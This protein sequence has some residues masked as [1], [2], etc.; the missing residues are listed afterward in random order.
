MNKIQ[1]ITF[2]NKEVRSQKQGIYVQKIVVPLWRFYVH[3]VWT[4]NNF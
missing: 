2:L 4:F 1:A 3:D